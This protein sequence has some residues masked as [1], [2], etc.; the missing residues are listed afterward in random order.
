MTH[1]E[2]S[3]HQLG[4]PMHRIKALRSPAAS[5]PDVQETDFEP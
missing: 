4:P 5:G 2:E 3:M 1:I